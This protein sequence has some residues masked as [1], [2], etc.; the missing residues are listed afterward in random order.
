MSIKS[1]IPGVVWDSSRNRWR[2]YSSGGKRVRI[3]LGS[4]PTKEGAEALRLKADI[5]VF[6]TADEKRSVVL[7]KLARI[8]MRVVWREVLKENPDQTWTS[9]DHFVS[10]VGDRPKVEKK[11]IKIGEAPI[12]PDNFKWVAPK[13]DFTTKSG[14][15]SYLKERYATDPLTY[16]KEEL[17]R[18]FGMTLDDYQEK[19]KEQNG[20]CAICSKPETAI[21]MGKLLPLAVDHC[22]RTGET[23][24]LLCTVCNI[25][26]GSLQ[27]D[28]EVLRTAANYIDKWK[29]IHEPKT[30]EGENIVSFNK[31]TS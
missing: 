22:H 12:G 18:K 14:R 11:L 26:I 28:P 15:K 7:D 30:P 24:G 10:T 4:S 16:R 8:R 19:L 20:V 25:G 27:D 3:Y 6:P 13:Y 29:K 17:K 1:N 9:F 31:P 2:A 23:R 5:G 21:R